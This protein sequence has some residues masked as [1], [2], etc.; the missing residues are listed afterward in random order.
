MKFTYAFL[1][2]VLMVLLSC[3][4]KNNS[5]TKN[6]ENLSDT[7]A[8]ID[9]TNGNSAIKST[10]EINSEILN[11]Y[12]VGDFIVQTLLE[13]PIIYGKNGVITSLHLITKETNNTNSIYNNQTHSM[14]LSFFENG[15]LSMKS[16]FLGREKHGEWIMCWQNGNVCYSNTYVEGSKEGT[17]VTYY[18][19]GVV[20]SK[21]SYLNNKRHG[22]VESYLNNGKLQS[23]TEYSNGIAIGNESQSV[24]TEYDSTDSNEEENDMSRNIKSAEEL[25]VADKKLNAIYKQVIAVLNETEKTALRHEQRKWI[26]NRDISCEEETKDSKGGSLYNAFLN[27]CEKEKTEKRIEELND[28]LQSKE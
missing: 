20:K 18:E 24:N 11:N 17:W 7:I 19:N 4:S 22:A 15:K 13:K 2:P 5:K 26:K 21:I 16:E 14:D 27:N 10:D 25:E 9:N 1:I 23:K 6:I 28:I 3:N 12:V 8:S